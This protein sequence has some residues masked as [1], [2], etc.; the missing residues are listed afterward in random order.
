M[1][2]YI[3]ALTISNLG[4]TVANQSFLLYNSSGEFRLII[5]SIAQFSLLLIALNKIERLTKERNIYKDRL[6][7]KIE[8]DRLKETDEMPIKKENPK[9][10]VEYR[11]SYEDWL[12]AKEIRMQEKN[13]NK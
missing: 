3:S 4:S 1:V 6:G 2:L 13:K 9:N 8:C 7:D 12:R 11:M 5:L 10:Y